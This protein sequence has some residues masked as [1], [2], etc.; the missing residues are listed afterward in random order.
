M[1]VQPKGGLRGHSR[2]SRE[3]LKNAFSFGERDKKNTIPHE[4]QPKC[5]I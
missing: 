2:S 5:K 1:Q 4:Q 3:R